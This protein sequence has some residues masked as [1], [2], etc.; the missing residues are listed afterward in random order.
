MRGLLA[1]PAAERR[2]PALAEEVV[3]R[4]FLQRR[5]RK[6]ESDPKEKLPAAESGRGGL[7]PS[8]EHAYA[9]V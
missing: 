2:C 1:A 9:N 3:D 8:P 4:D 6:T 5:L 7:A